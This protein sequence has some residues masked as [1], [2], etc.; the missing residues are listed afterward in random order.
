MLSDGGKI[1]FSLDSE[2]PLVKV[3]CFIFSI[4]RYLIVYK[5]L[6]ELKLACNTGICTR[7]IKD[8]AHEIIFRIL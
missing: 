7:Y 5:I 8:C 4:F 2:F 6:F 3:T 1:E